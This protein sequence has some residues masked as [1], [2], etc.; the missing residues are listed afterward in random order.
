MPTLEASFTWVLLSQ[1]STIMPTTLFD[2]GLLQHPYLHPV[3]LP[4]IG[5][6]ISIVPL[7]AF[8]AANQPGFIPATDNWELNHVVHPN[9]IEAHPGDELIVEANKEEDKEIDEDLQ[10]LMQ[11]DDEDMDDGPVLILDYDPPVET[12]I[13]DDATQYELDME[14]FQDRLSGVCPP[15]QQ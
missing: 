11:D 8:L 14:D 10:I 13:L 5:E 12:S 6:P 4:P 3:H 7:A 15:I 1:C 9:P 2:I